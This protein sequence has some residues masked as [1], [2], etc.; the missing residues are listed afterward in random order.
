[1]A[2]PR[3]GE[4]ELLT[5]PAYWGWYLVVITKKHS[6]WRVVLIPWTS[7]VTLA[8][9][10]N[11]SAHRPL[12][13]ATWDR[14]SAHLAGM[15]WEPNENM[16]HTMFNVLLS[17]KAERMLEIWYA[18]YSQETLDEWASHLWNSEAWLLFHSWE[19]K[20]ILKDYFNILPCLWFR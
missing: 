9:L 4:A 18:V 15:L 6:P 19:D 16:A 17:H 3:S 7:Y 14:L 12:L 20:G 5:Y 2:R 13:S 8:K 11:Q 10:C 1:M